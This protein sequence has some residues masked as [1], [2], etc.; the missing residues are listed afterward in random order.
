[1]WAARKP[2]DMM[3]ALDLNQ[4]PNMNTQSTMVQLGAS[5]DAPRRG[6]SDPSRAGLTPMPRAKAVF[7]EMTSRAPSDTS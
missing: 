7:V 4:V 1:M 6:T 5:A 3:R 2:P